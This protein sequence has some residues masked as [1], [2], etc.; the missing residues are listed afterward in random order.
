M[1]KAKVILIDDEF[2][3]RKQIRVKIETE[4][5]GIEIVG[6]YFDAKSALEE[7]E[8]LQPDIVI[9]DIC[10]PE[11]DGICF[12]ELCA[13]RFPGTKVI[14]ITESNDYGVSKEGYNENDELVF[15]IM[16]HANKTEME[17]TTNA[18]NSNNPA[19]QTVQKPDC[20]R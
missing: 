5:L 19:C 6:E 4:E 18:G 16:I 1:N 14:L 8:K 20:R 17:N 2:L 12:S 11:M 15:A 3:I 7:M 9:S 13:E 10:M